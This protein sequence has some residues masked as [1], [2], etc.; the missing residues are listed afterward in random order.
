MDYLA[1]LNKHSLDDNISFTPNGHRYTIKHPGCPQGDTNFLSV[2]TFVHSLLKPFDDNR[3][4]DNM[5][6]SDNWSKNK[7]Y[8]MTKQQIKQQWRQNGKLARDA[9]TKLHYDIECVYNNMPTNNNSKEFNDFIKFKNDHLD[10]VP[11]RTE[12]LIYDVSL[13]FAGS[14]DMIFKKNDNTISIYDWKRVKELEKVSKYNK[15]FE[16]SCVEHLPDT[17]YWHYALQLNI[18]KKIIERNYGLLVD[19][20]N[21]V[22]LHPDLPTYKVVKLPILDKEV[23]AL[24]LERYYKI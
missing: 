18:Y 8:G 12:W 5:M 4:I 23:E 21:L 15:W 17:N 9:G 6:K 19:E 3:I 22:C 14:I 24:F 7:Y 13:R 20:I 10:L 11:F 2:T 16:N 1:K